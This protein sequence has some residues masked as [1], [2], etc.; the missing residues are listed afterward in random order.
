MPDAIRELLTTILD[1]GFVES[2]SGDRFLLKSNI[3]R[4]ECDFLSN[5]I[6]SD[7]SIR[8]TLEIGC[9]YGISSLAICDAIKDRRAPRHRIIDPFQT[10]EWRGIG[11]LNLRRAGVGFAEWIEERSEYAL[12]RLAKADPDSLDLVLID[13]W[14]T[15]DHTLLDIFY[16]DRLIRVGGYIVI[17]DATWASVSRA[18]AYLSTYP[19]YEFYGQTS[20]SH[21]SAR[22]RLARLARTLD[23]VRALLIEWPRPR[24]QRAIARSG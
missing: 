10:T 8:E 20:D 2:E 22:R 15:F 3:S 16:A 23:R 24:G 1:R 6:G 4:D 21:V 12:P 5:L 17:D 7:H 9:A 13:G 14:H 19:N 18:C 11:L